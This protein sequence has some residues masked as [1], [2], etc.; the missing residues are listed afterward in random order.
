M[1]NSKSL[2]EVLKTLYDTPLGPGA[3]AVLADLMTSDLFEDE[4]N[5]RVLGSGGYL[6]TA[7]R[8]R[9]CSLMPPL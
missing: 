7:R 5:D 2:G 8:P 4:F 6:R 1:A 9:F 3:D